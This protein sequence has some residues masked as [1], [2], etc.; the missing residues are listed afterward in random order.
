L[1]KPAKPD[2]LNIDHSTREISQGDSNGKESETESQTAGGKS[3]P[4]EQRCPQD[5]ESRQ[6][7]E[8]YG[9]E[10]RQAD[11]EEAPQERPQSASRG[12]DAFSFA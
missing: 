12:E 4:Q 11:S 6:D 5:Q 10:I 9:Q 7:Q 8:G 3:G 1:Q 2:D